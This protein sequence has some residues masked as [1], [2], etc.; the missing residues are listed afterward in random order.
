MTQTINSELISVGTEILLGEITDTNSVYLARF[1]RDYGINVLYMTSV[2]DNRARIAQTVKM[3]MARSN[4]V[5]MCGGLGPTVDDMTREAVADATDRELEFHEYLYAQIADRFRSFHAVMSENNRRQAYVPDGA[6][7]LE[8]A[9]GTAPGFAVEHNG[10]L[11]VALPGVP[12]EMKF[13]MNDKVLPLLKSRYDLSVIL[14]RVLHTAGI[15]ESALDELIG[16]E[17]LESGNPT[18]GL[19]AHNGQVDV[20]ITAKAATR[21]DAE[22]MIETVETDL[23]QR[24]GRYVYGVDSETLA[25]TLHK[26]L[27]QRNIG[28]S[29]VECG[30]A[31]LLADLG[32]DVVDRKAY[33]TVAALLSELPDAQDVSYRSIAEAAGR[34]LADSGEGTSNRA[35]VVVVTAE[36][37]DEAS[38]QQP[39]TSVYVSYGGRTR[40]R[41]YGFGARSE[42][43]RSWVET[44]SMAQLWWM[45]EEQA[46][47]A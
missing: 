3:A 35:C 23:R 45:I 37:I 33:P 22:A 42:L 44:W 13:L 11:V 20:R 19:A 5:I 32:T 38:D 17:L 41:S 40:S 2:G 1:L 10:S 46:A 6:I 36:D 16:N 14:P 34:V 43:I 28:V 8:N 25:G 29:L 4:I 15:G 27:E 31:G 12:R 26:R 39:G 47:H 30:I 7:V 18:V 9:V 24:I 21:A